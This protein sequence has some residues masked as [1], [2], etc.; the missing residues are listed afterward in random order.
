MKK[1]I[2][3]LVGSA[4]ANNFT[5]KAVKVLENYLKAEDDLSY[6][7]IDPAQLTLPM[8]GT[9]NTQ[10]SHMEL[11]AAVK[12]ATGVIIASPEYHGGISS[13]MKLM[14]DHLGFPSLLATKPIAL[15]G[16]ASGAIGAIKSLEQ[17]RSICS[18]VGSIVLP[19]AVSIANVTEAFDKTGVCSAKIELQIQSV[20]K[21]LLNYIEKTSP[22][23]TE[24][25]VQIASMPSY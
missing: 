1:H 16:V 9:A 20:A 25:S 3:I 21:N 5:M 2:V 18:H 23:L 13:V 24:T 19:K 10:S 6:E 22:K 11:Q 8:P 15:L 12:E 7:I 4:R 14:I 17:T